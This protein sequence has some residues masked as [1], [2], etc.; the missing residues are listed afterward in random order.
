[1]AKSDFEGYKLT[2]YGKEF[3]WPV[4]KRKE[5]AFCVET[6]LGNLWL[7]TSRMH[8]SEAEVVLLDE[9]RIEQYLDWL[10]FNLNNDSNFYIYVNAVESEALANTKKGMYQFEYLAHNWCDSTKKWLE[11]GLMTKEVELPRSEITELH[12]QT[13][14]P[15]WLMKTKVAGGGRDSL[16]PVRI[17]NFDSIKE[18]ISVKQI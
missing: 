5:W 11:I 16:S 1:M 18:L 17:F 3:F 7:E 6:E 2:I 12:G 8:F 4:L 14:A 9:E 15:F 13:V 10:Q